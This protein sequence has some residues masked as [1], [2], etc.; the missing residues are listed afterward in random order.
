L[1]NPTPELG[2]PSR[3][4]PCGLIPVGKFVE[5][6]SIWPI[7]TNVEWVLVYTS[8]SS[9]SLLILPNVQRRQSNFICRTRFEYR[10][11]TPERHD[12]CPISMKRFSQRRY[13]IPH[14]WRLQIIIQQS[15]SQG[16]C[17]RVRWMFTWTPA[18]NQTHGWIRKEVK[19]KVATRGG[20]PDGSNVLGLR[21][22]C[23]KISLNCVYLPG[24]CFLS[25]LIE[26]SV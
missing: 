10:D 26:C 17:T 1:A 20:K 8:G 18:M 6:N 22:N 11:W 25:I 19:C 5:E 16:I 14:H 4:G 24:I 3:D 12:S 21:F 2:N 15:T 9:G 7:S 23:S 13:N